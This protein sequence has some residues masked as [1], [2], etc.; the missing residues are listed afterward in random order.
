MSRT[1]RWGSRRNASSTKN[2]NLCR[3]KHRAHPGVVWVKGSRRGTRPPPNRSRSSKLTTPSIWQIRSSLSSSTILTLSSRACF[4]KSRLLPISMNSLKL[5]ILIQ[6]NR[7]W[8][9][10]IGLERWSRCRSRQGH[11]SRCRPHRAAEMSSL[12]PCRLTASTWTSKIRKW[13]AN[14]DS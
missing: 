11:R 3:I 12:P 13:R 10:S 4:S 8:S 9:S 5:S 14:Q 6:P 2:D 7:E 1:C